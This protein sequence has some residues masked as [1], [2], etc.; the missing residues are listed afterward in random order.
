MLMKKSHLPVWISFFLSIGLFCAFIILSLLFLFNIVPGII[1][2]EYIFEFVAIIPGPMY[3]D[4]LILYIIPILIY[5]LIKSIAPNLVFILY[6][7]NKFTFIFRVKPKYG[8]IKE[9]GELKT[10]QTI[11]RII[12]ISLFAFATSSILVQLGF[13]KLFRASGGFG[14]LQ[15]AEEIFFGTFFITGICLFLF[16]PLW[17]LEDSGVVAFRSYKDRRKTPIMEGIHNLFANL[18]ELYTGLTTVQGYIAL[19]ITTF[20]VLVPGDQAILT[21]IVLIILPFV[22]TGLFAIPFYLYEKNLTNIRARIHSK[23]IKKGLSLINI[24]DFEDL[25]IKEG[26]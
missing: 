15:Y 6:K 4:I 18:L 21:P 8:I 9:Q 24:P 25:T 14:S 12:L 11:F 2:K 7:I 26:K 3:T 5:Y 20:S 17:L 16:A 10:G 1:P 19:I 13:G 23:L 22:I